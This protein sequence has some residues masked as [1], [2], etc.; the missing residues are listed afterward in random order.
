MKDTR[1]VL[2]AHI[3]YTLLRPGCTQQ[4]IAQL[5]QTA[6][7]HQFAAV[8]VPPYHLLAAR[9]YTAGSTVQRCTVVGFP[10]GMH[11]A[12]TKH[13]EA[14]HLLREGAEELDMV[15]NLCMVRDQR[16]SEI[17]HEIAGFTALCSEYQAV[18]KIIIESGVLSMDEV[19]ILC[20][21]CTAAGA[22]F[23]KTSTGYAATG[24]ELEKVQFMREILPTHI[25]IK[26]SGGIRT[27]E[28]ALA[29][30]QAGAHR[31][32]TSALLIEA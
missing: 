12:E 11:L 25:R 17:S 6:V 18:S 13:A 2:A 22:D 3:D 21:L 10:H 7:Q 23:V 19:K 16:W 32:G 1:D 31:I 4:E 30:I 15:I 27:R 29:Y 5:C 9:Q 26:A 24:A 14:E 20:E 28:A 8:C